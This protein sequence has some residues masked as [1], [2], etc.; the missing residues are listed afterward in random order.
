MFPLAELILNESGRRPCFQ[1]LDKHTE[2]SMHCSQLTKDYISSPFYLF[3]ILWYDHNKLIR[4]RLILTWRPTAL[5]R[6]TAAQQKCANFPFWRAKQRRRTEGDRCRGNSPE[7]TDS[8][9][10]LKIWCEW[11]SDSISSDI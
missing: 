5:H 3:F 6:H 1:R 2:N 9:T 11:Y 8:L 10:T 4:F 7:E